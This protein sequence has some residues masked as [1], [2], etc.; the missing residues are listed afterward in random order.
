MLR[1]AFLAIRFIR[2]PETG[3]SLEPM[4]RALRKDDMRR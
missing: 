4:Q 2:I 1:F 3:H